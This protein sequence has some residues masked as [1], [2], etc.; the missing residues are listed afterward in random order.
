MEV[1]NS[2]SQFFGGELEVIDCLRQIPSNSYY[3]FSSNRIIGLDEIGVD[4]SF[5]VHFRLVGGKGGLGSQLKSKRTAKSSNQLMCRDLSGRRHGEV[6]E[7][8]RLRKWV[9]KKGEREK[10]AARKK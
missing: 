2:R 10:E 4:D 1:F 7:E 3:L 8:E 5:E 6:R 9:E